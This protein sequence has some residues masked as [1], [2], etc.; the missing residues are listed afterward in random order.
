MSLTFHEEFEDFKDFIV[1]LIEGRA[2]VGEN[3]EDIFKSA[4]AYFFKG[5]VIQDAVL[6]EQEGLFGVHIIQDEFF[7][8]FHPSS[9]ILWTKLLSYLEFKVAFVFYFSFDFC[10]TQYFLDS[11]ILAL[12]LQSFLVLAEDLIIL[13]ENI[14]TH[15]FLEISESGLYV[16]EELGIVGRKI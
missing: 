14:Q 12:I 11:L 9:Q 4:R 2:H 13:L 8:N 16:C 1:K 3:E 15:V 10:C 7:G 5:F 6:A